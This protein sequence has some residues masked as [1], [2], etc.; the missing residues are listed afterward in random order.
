[1]KSTEKPDRPSGGRRPTLRDIALRVGVS[2]GTVSAILNNA[3]RARN[4][5]E[6]TNRR[7][8]ETAEE[9]GYVPNPLGR[10]LRRTFSGTIGCLSFKQPDIYYGHLLRAAEE[11]FRR[12][13][14]EPVMASMNY[15]RKQFGKCLWQLAAWRVEGYLLMMGGRPLDEEMCAA[16]RQLGLPCIIVDAHRPDGNSPSTRLNVESGRLIAEHLSDLGHEHLAVIGINYSNCHIT[17]RLEGILQVMRE[18]NLR[19]PKHMIVENSKRLLGPQV[20]Y[21][22]AGEILDR[23]PQSTAI[24]CMNDIIATGAMY[25]LHERGVNIPGD[26]SVTG[27]DDVCVDV[28]VMEDNRLGAYLWPSLT[29]VRVPH[30]EM[31]Q[32]AAEALLECMADP[33]A[34]EHWELPLSPLLVPRNS[35]ARVCSR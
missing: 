35:S 28:T 8:R 4:Y 1:M 9:L 6:E 34:L 3:P 24:I 7:I 23:C 27:F 11:E 10:V 16:I 32:R 21:V 14:Y 2:Q 15:D 29:T 20:G 17:E 31:G 25:M 12:R 26:M 22:Y 18:R 5:S 19:L 13:G 33:A 30:G